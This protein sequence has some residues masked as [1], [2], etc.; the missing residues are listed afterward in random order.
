MGENEALATGD[1]GN[2]EKASDAGINV[3]IDERADRGA[4]QDFILNRVTGT[5]SGWAAAGR[6]FSGP[7]RNRCIVVPLL[8]HPKRSSSD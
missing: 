7:E 8:G 6:F 3:I 1:L 4:W 2:V 5:R